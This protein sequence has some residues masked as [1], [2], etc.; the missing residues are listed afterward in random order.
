MALSEK[1]VKTAKDKIKTDQFLKKF[2]EN[3]P[4]PINPFKP[5]KPKFERM[6]LPLPKG[7]GPRF[8]RP[9]DPKENPE[10]YR[11]FIEKFKKEKAKKKK[12]L[13][14]TDR[15]KKRKNTQKNVFADGGKA[16]S[17]GMLSVKAGVDN[18]PNPTQADR[19]V[20]ATKKKNGG[21]VDSPKK[22]DK[23]KKMPGMLAIGIEII[24]PKKPIKAKDGGFT[25][26]AGI[27]FSADNK[28]RRG[29]KR[30]AD[31]DAKF[32]RQRKAKK[33]GSLAG[34]LAKRGYGKARS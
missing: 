18:N 8:G 4:D 32:K 19:I 31:L 10:A 27:A 25:G 16:E 2:K 7:F 21:P 11:K 15:K 13:G 28:L 30:I 9:P 12:L 24:K 34:R 6:P 14:D 5:K 29:L 22:K 33:T 1:G 26:R 20:G 17:F 23:K 3:Q